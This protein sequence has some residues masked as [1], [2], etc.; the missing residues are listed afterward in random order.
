MFGK[1]LLL[2]IT[3][4]MIELFILVKLGTIIGFWQ[5][6]AIVIITGI[7]GASLARLQGFMVFN[8]IQTE[9]QSGQ[10]PADRMVDGLLIFIGGVVLLTPG[11][12]TDLAGFAMLVPFTR[13]ATKKY[14]KRKFEGHIKTRDETKYTVIDV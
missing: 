7:L 6:V 4:P 9:L 14:L 1:L 2:F 11:L 12:L 10:I 3:I 13:N 5:T 8:Q